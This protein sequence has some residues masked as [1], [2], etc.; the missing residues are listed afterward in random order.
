[1]HP[2][3]EARRPTGAA[4]KAGPPLQRGGDHLPNWTTAELP[5]APPVRF[6]LGNM[7]GPGLIMAGA[8]IGG[9]EWLIGPA[10]TAKYGG[11]LLWIATVSI[12]FQAMFNLEVMRYAIFC[13]ESIFVGFF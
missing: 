4:D 9:G 3:D 12:L 6:R 7:L 10:L 2:D 1:M 11:T 8:A 13:G 5:E